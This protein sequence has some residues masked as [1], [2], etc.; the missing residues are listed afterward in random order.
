MTTEAATPRVG[1]V[2]LSCA[3]PMDWVMTS[4]KPA[5]ACLARLVIGRPVAGAHVS[6]APG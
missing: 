5:L 2:C 6:R 3:S 4:V 1:A